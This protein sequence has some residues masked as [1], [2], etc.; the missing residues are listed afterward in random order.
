M[1]RNEN[2]KTLSWEHHDGLVAAFRLIQGLKNKVDT[3]ILSGYIIHIWEKALLHHFWQEEQMIPE[4]IENLPAGKELLGKMMADHR[5][6]DLLIAKIKDD[7]QSLPH[8]KEF[9]E[10]LN[11][12]I[13]FEERE[14]FP[15]LEKTVTADKLVEIGTFLDVQ[16]R[17]PNND[18]KAKF[19]QTSG[20]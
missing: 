1:K 9:A 16:H 15:F 7:P 13:H 17:P 4:Q 6:F 11:Q 10:L 8:V 5:V 14:L 12:H 18:W 20:I 19:W 3:A 2:L